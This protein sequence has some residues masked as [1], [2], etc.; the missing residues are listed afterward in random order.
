MAAKKVSVRGRTAFF[1][2]V[3]DEAAVPGYIAAAAG[4][5]YYASPD[6][7][8]FIPFPMAEVVVNVEEYE[9][10][11]RQEANNFGPGNLYS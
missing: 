7:D 6:T 11:G 2:I 4:T 9:Q 3:M 10:S 8:I 1:D 5:G